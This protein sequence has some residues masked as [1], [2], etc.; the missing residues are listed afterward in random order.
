MG[1]L[2]ATPDSF[3]AESR[4]QSEEAVAHMARQLDADGADIIDIGACSTRPGA[5]AV[6]AADEAAR[7]EAAVKITRQEVPHAIISVDTFRADIAQRAVEDWGADMVND[8][9]GGN[10]DAEM[11]D[12]MAALR[13]PYVLCH[14]RGELPHMMEHA[15]YADV[16]TEVLQEL[17]ER[18][19]KL[20]LLGVADVI[21]DPG[22]GFSKTLEQ[23]YALLANLRLFEILGRPLLVGV[24]RKSMATKLLDI[25]A[26]EA[27]NA[28]TALNTLA[29]DR[30]ADILRVHDPRAA[31]EAIAVWSEVTKA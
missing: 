17:A 3:F 11:F 27:L 5:I 16:C 9:S 2:N 10:L 14:S 26:S 7:L 23:N 8:I 20:A 12:I 22:F 19:E 25:P 4:A 15:R 1:I 24:S 6:V 28:T 30:G 21:V 31:R 29:L 18:L 13:A